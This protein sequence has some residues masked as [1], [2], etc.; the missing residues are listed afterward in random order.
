MSTYPK[1]YGNMLGI[2]IQNNDPEQRGRV[3][4]F[5]PHISPNVYKGWTEVKKDKKFKFIGANTYSDLTSVLEDLKKILPWAECASPLTSEASSGRYNSS[6]STGTIS[7][8]NKLLTT[9]SNLTSSAIDPTKLT[10]YSQNKDNIGEKPGNIF[11]I[12]YYKLKDA[13]ADITNNNNNVNKLS[14]NYTPECYSNSAKGSFTVPAVGSHLWV[15]CNSGDPLK[16]VYFATQ[17]GTEDWSSIYQTN[18][19]KDLDY[20][21]AYEN[22]KVK[23]S[24]DFSI[25]TDSYRN[26]FVINQKGGTIQ[27]VNS[28]NRELL[29]LTHFSGSFKEFNNYANIELATGNDQKLVLGD[30]FTTIKNSKNEYVELDFDQIIKGDYYRKIGNLN[31]SLA[32]KWKSIVQ[33]I[34]NI[35]QLFDIQRASSYSGVGLLNLTNPQQTKNGVPAKCPVCST[36]LNTYFFYNNSYNPQFTNTV[37]NT[38][39]D[40]SGDYIYSVSIVGSTGVVSSVKYPGSLG[41]V[42]YSSP[43]GSLTGSVDGSAFVSG[44]GNIFGITCPCCGGSTQSP[45]SQDGNWT[46]EQA[47]QTLQSKINNQIANLAAIE[48]QLGIGGSEIIEITKHKIETIGTVMNDFGSIRVDQAGKCYISEVLIGKYGVFY[49]RKATPLIEYV[50][51]DDLPGGNYTLNVCNRY[52]LQVGSGGMNL[53]S[54]GPTNIAGAITNVTGEQVNIGSEQETNIDG[55]KRLSLIADVISIRQRNKQQVVIEGNLGVTSNITVAG[56]QHVE[57]ELFVNHITAPIEIQATEQSVVYA[58]GA[59]DQNN[60][61]G[62]IIGYGVPLANF[63]YNNT[64]GARSYIGKTDGGI[65]IGATTYN[66]SKPI[67]FIAMGT[68][69]GSNDGGPV[70]A[71]ADIP[72]YGGTPTTHLSTA[73]IYGTDINGVYGSNVGAGGADASQMPII[74]YGTGRDHD[75]IMIEPH[76]HLFKNVPLTLLDTNS[77]V[78]DN[79]SVINN[80]NQVNCSPIVNVK[81]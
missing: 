41:I 23:S 25:N 56:A 1:Y 18:S 76:S 79:A 78:R 17:F 15:F 64:T 55:G 57:G 81:K 75:S 65:T 73:C 10:P 47:K 61:N 70:V 80:Y 39:A 16:P 59:T 31:Q 51:V 2:C 44:N 6:R 33:E 60:Q 11:D 52:N 30:Q 36:P 43:A 38:I 48:Q 20:P 3:K 8:S 14:Y 49:N 40:S 66:P 27:F 34:A 28:D 9:V 42:N 22:I 74:I 7:D 12:S 5:I 24:S 69:L 46:A 37:N 72:I 13:F 35:K 19:G 67:G 45:S 58:A 32:S 53:K 29:K 26:K 63:Y 71:P 50:H 62:K 77:E 54:Y 4:V 68:V 21:G